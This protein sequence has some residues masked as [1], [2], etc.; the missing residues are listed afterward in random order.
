M[1]TPGQQQSAAK[2]MS[3]TS[4]TIADL[5]PRED[6]SAAVKAGCADG[7]HLTASAEGGHATS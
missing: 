4:E 2:Q 3:E 6:E 1:T 7:R 5:Q